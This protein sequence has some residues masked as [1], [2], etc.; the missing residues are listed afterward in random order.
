MQTKLTKKVHLITM[1]HKASAQFSKP[2]LTSS[3]GGTVLFQACCQHLW[4]IY[5]SVKWQSFG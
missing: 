1:I 5:R 4:D 2:T 3:W